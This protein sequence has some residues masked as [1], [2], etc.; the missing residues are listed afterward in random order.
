MEKMVLD[1]FN[2]V[3]ENKRILITGHTGFKGSWLSM[4]LDQL[5]AN[6]TGLSLNPTEEFSHW[7]DIRIKNIKSNIGDIR[8]FEFT[9]DVLTKSDPEIIFHLAAQ[10]LVKKSYDYPLE[11]WQ[12][13]VLGT[14][15]LLEISR[16]LKNLKSIIIITSDKC[17][18]NLETN[19]L[20]KET[21]RLG[22]FDPYSSSKAA[23]EILVNSFQKSFFNSKNISL[24]TARAGNV[25]GGGDWSEN[26]LIPDLIK[27]VINKEQLLIRYPK[28]T[29]PWQHVLDCIYGYLKLSEATL[30]KKIY[31]G[32]YN[33]GPELSS[34]KNVEEV[35]EKMKKYWPNISWKTEKNI[36]KYESKLLNLDSQKAFKELD[37]KPILNLDQSIE[38]TAE[39]YKEY[40]YENVISLKQLSNYTDKINAN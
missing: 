1:N 21:D 26:R 9:N 38:L 15:N 6:I 8:D 29:R 5:N 25:I 32:S 19:K 30:N 10:P 35:L 4:W 13:N 12:T 28:A 11:T 16:K 20:Y 39:W 33:F 22:G 31:S 14:A 3:F 7:K 2:K 27:S 17:Y 23:V 34:N 40:N 18:E 24:T 36:V 37:W